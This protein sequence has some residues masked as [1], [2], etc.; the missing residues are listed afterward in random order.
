[1]VT[2]HGSHGRISS[3]D[4]K[5]QWSIV[6]RHGYHWHRNCLKSIMTNFYQLID[7]FFSINVNIFH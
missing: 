4:L 2:L 1:M 5:K 3:S 6:L 7:L